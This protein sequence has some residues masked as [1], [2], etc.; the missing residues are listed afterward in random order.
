[1][2]AREEQCEIAARPLKLA[3]GPPSPELDAL[4]KFQKEEQQQELERL[5]AALAVLRSALD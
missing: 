2:I 5:D 1:M 3:E 4:H